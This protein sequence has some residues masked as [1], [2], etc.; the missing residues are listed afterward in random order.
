ME[1]RTSNVRRSLFS[2]AHP[3]VIF[4]YF[5]AVIVLCMSTLN[6]AF[7]LLSYVGASALAIF[8][9]GLR[10]YG[11]TCLVFIPVFLVIT[12][13]NALF[14]HLG[15]TFLFHAGP[16]RLSLEALIYGATS[17]LM[18][19]SV[20]LWFLSYQNIMTT[21]KF[22]CLFGRIMPATSLIMSMIFRYIPLLTNRGHEILMSQKNL[23]GDVPRKK[24][25]SLSYGA[26]LSSILMGW[27]LEQ[28]IETADSMRARGFGSHKR[29]T[30]TPFSFGGFDVVAL[31]LLAFLT[32]ISL[33]NLIVARADFMFYPYFS[34]SLPHA[35]VT[36]SYALLLL[37]PFLVELEGALSCRI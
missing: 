21:D 23:M 24:L 16:L 34:L 18:L 3:A 6:P 37:F 28:S 22:L 11:K 19:L 33:Y 10:R 7:V 30:Y 12:L 27:S 36:T 35:L 1:E 31:M 29:T 8:T 26:R 20:I 17:A 32:I 13:A 4:L 14:N 2:L 9:S 25:Q 5:C 15:E